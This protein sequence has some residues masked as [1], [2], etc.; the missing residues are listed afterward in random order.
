MTRKRRWFLLSAAL[1]TVL[2]VLTVSYVRAHPLVF[3][4]THAH[5]I[6]CAGLALEIYADQHQGR[7]PFDPKGYPSA[8]LMLDEGY[9]TNLTGPGYEAAPLIEAKR[10]GKR[11]SEEECGRVYVQGLTTKSNQEIALLFDKLPTPG[12]DHCHLPLRLWQPLGRE[13]WCVGTSRS[14]IPESEWA[15]FTR[16]QVD[17]LTQEGFDR[18]EA[19]RLFTSKP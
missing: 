13:V 19:E 9:F 12:G 7:F 17:L 14:F 1:V 15:E 6:Q 4:P 16:K 18:A 2:T 11:L 10:T 8:L 3:M 5:C